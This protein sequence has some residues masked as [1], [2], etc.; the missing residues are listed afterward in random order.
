MK[1]RREKEQETREEKKD[2][3]PKRQRA[4][5]T[6]DSFET[7]LEFQKFCEEN[8]G[9]DLHPVDTNKKYYVYK[10]P[11]YSILKGSTKRQ[12]MKFLNYNLRPIC[13]DYNIK[14][15]EDGD[16][17]TAIMASDFI[18]NTHSIVPDIF[19]TGRFVSIKDPSISYE[20]LSEKKYGKSTGEKCIATDCTNKGNTKYAGYCTPCGKASL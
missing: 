14:W 17:L 6:K 13:S 3:Q 16:F 1:R 20:S 11:D 8:L 9:P 19:K 4:E 5:G 18:P 15:K 12:V 2:E 10:A 7:F